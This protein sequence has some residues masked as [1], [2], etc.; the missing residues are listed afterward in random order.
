MALTAKLFTA[1]EEMA[2]VVFKIA[3][4]SRRSGF[5]KIELVTVMTMKCFLFKKL[6]W[7]YVLV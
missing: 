2:V 6:R 1:H 3:L 7:K 4:K 5:A